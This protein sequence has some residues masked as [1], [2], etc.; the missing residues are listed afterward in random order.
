MNP[1]MCLLLALLIA[2]PYWFFIFWP[3]VFTECQLWFIIG[4]VFSALVLAYYSIIG[5]FDWLEKEEQKPKNTL[6]KCRPNRFKA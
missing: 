6:Q 5:Y 1:A 3:S 4:Q 2:V